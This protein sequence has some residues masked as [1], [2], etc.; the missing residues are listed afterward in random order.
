MRR[1]DNGANAST[2]L[3]TRSPD[4]EL[5]VRRQLGRGSY[6]IN[7]S[8]NRAEPP[9]PRLD[10]NLTSQW[11]HLTPRKDSVDSEPSARGS[12][13]S[14]QTGAPPTQPAPAV[15]GFNEIETRQPTE[16]T[17]PLREDFQSFISAPQ[18]YK[19]S[20]R[21]LP[22]AQLLHKADQATRNRPQQASTFRRNDETQ[23]LGAH[24][25]RA[26]G[27]LDRGPATDRRADSGKEQ[28]TI[29]RRTKHSANESAKEVKG[30]EAPPTPVRLKSK[31]FAEDIRDE[32]P[33]KG[34]KGRG[35]DKSSRRAQFEEE[36][37]DFDFDEEDELRFQ[38]KR[39]RK[40]KKAARK[41]AKEAAAAPIPIIL[42]E[43]ISVSNLA[44]ALKVK[45]EDFMWKLEDLGF[46]GVQHDH[47]LNAENAGLVAMEYNFEPVIDRS[48]TED[49]T[50]RPPVEDLSKLPPR[51]PVVT[52]MGHVD[53]GKTTLLDFL[54]KSS[55]AASEH[56]GITQHIGAFSVSMASG[57][58]ITFLDTPGHAAFLSMRQRGANVTDIVIL[59]VAADD[60][61]KPQTIEAIKHAKAAKVPIIVAV[62]KIDKEEA[63]PERVKQ[64]LARYGVEIEDFGG[65]TQVVCVSGKT[66][67]G[68]EELEEAVLTLAEILDMRAESDGPAEGW[69]IEASTKKAGRVATIL[70]KRGTLHAGDVIVA[71][72]TW[73]RVR[74]LRNEAG[75]EQPS[76]GPGT[77]VEV[78]GWRGQPVAGDEVL[79]AR[80]EQKATSVV[81][82][83]AAQ[84][85]RKRLAADVEAINE[86]RKAE[87]ERRER[88]ELATKAA[89]AATEGEESSPSDEAAKRD[90]PAATG[91]QEVYLI[92]KADVSGSAEAVSSSILS[93]THPEVVPHILRASVGAVSEFDVEHA[94]SAHGYIVNFNQAI[95]PA[96]SQF[97]E[98]KGVK[99]VDQNIIYRLVDEVKA[100]MSEKL[101]PTVTK[102]VLGE[103]EVA[104]IFE[105]NIGG[106]KTMAIAGCKVRN[107]TISKNAKIRVL[108]G[109]EVIYDGMLLLQS[110]LIVVTRKDADGT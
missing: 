32:A 17:L 79:Q 76:A 82:Y 59:V 4:S 98:E 74:S 35:R 5:P 36:E 85:E 92:V 84:A 37:D 80:N 72:T 73:A 78:D 30:Y 105:I 8:F 64:D 83:R 38:R 110:L 11:K 100:T 95:P 13:L 19:A 58:L 7:L 77:P 10:P 16:H 25:G 6:S 14:A 91:P 43:Y 49:L 70:V 20:V 88:E 66:G 47:I 21:P 23:P 101:S 56:G 46:P 55:V 45:L 51:P 106:R 28:G 86:S 15:P 26:L 3:G 87:Q 108:R 27:S 57:K 18:A 12:E 44:S 24:D 109:K 67:Q 42:P 41:A 40:K 2:Q 107:G 48:E 62:N 33:Q 94:S 54:R 63:N 75:V 34:A 104:Q 31:K 39:D 50:P 90:P 60:S 71:G 69:I 29:S 89:K 102:R 22:E 68:M 65:D 103:A 52:I 61:V 99:I 53:H 97:A 1:N 96:I 9:E 81:A 93:L